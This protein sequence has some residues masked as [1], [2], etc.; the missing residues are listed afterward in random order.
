MKL[1]KKLEMKKAVCALIFTDNNK[2]LA[3][4][5]KDDSTDFGL[6]GGKVDPGETP[7]EALIRE[8]K[9]ET[10]LD[11]VEYRQVF[12]IEDSG[13]VCTTYLCQVSGQI[14]SNEKGVVKE[15]DWVDL[16]KG[17]FGSY[18]SQLFNHLCKKIFKI[19]QKKD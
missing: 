2:I 14:S 11:V 13:F 7:E 8:T 10:G 16:F 9:E 6:V 18:N 1:D 15:V 17:T 4:S 3:V 19:C 5:R 12:E